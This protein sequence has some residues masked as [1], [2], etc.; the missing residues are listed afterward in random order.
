M[1][2]IIHT[3]IPFYQVLGKL[4]YAIASTDNKVKKEEYDMLKKVIKSHWV[5]VDSTEDIHG[6]GIAFQIEIIF[7]WLSDFQL[8]SDHCFE[9]FTSYKGKHP[10]LFSTE[11]EQ[12]IW[13]TANEIATVSSR[14]NNSELV[15]LAKLKLALD[16]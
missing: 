2:D 6:S 12:R 10:S 5:S 4:F 1:E 14:K 7:D 16:T 13:Q 11:I 15:I 9:A 3:G 8:N